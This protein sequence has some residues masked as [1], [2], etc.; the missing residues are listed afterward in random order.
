MAIVQCKGCGNNVDLPDPRA[1]LINQLT[2]SMIVWSHGEPIL[3]PTCGM[4]FI[5]QIAGIPMEHLRC[6]YS[7]VP[8]EQLPDNVKPQRAAQQSRII[9]PFG[10]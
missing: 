9:S 5:G 1:E 8:K 4:G 10:R 3:C 6:V 2:V 7:A